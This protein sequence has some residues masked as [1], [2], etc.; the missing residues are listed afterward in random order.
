[1]RTLLAARF[2]PQFF[3]SRLD[4]FFPDSSSA[5][6]SVSI[7]LPQVFQISEKLRLPSPIFPVAHDQALLTTPSFSQ[8]T[9]NN[10]RISYR[11]FISF[12]HFFFSF[13]LPFVSRKKKSRFTLPRISP[14]IQGANFTPFRILEF[15][16]PT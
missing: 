13:A 3:R 4:H 6:S 5:Q 15:H 16:M 8:F 9:I 2:F 12:L 1:M 10:C 14:R 11:G 7:S